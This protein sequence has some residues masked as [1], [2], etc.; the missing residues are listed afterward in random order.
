MRACI[1]VDA[2]PCYPTV[3]GVPCKG[4]AAG[5]LAKTTTFPPC[6]ETM[7]AAS[8]LSSFIK[9]SQYLVI[10]YFLCSN[11]KSISTY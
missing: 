1:I 3:A 4:G 9:S 5:T 11:S 8:S 10:I 6:G 7:F 2:C